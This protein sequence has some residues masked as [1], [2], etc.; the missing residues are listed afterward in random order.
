MRLR[1]PPWAY[2]SG[3]PF[4]A[5]T[6]DIDSL[7]RTSASSPPAAGAPIYV[8]VIV[9][10][11]PGLSTEEAGRVFERFYRVTPSRSRTHGG[12]GLDLAIAAAIT[13][14]HGGR[15]DLDIEPAR[16][17]LSAWPSP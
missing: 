12:S 10:R 2:A 1:E 13:Q 4:R 3:H 11:G 5:T 16:D 6:G 17:A 8:I 15:M 14:G 9:D 7:G